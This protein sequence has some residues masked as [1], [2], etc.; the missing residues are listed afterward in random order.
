M[1][2][3]SESGGRFHVWRQRFPDGKPEQLTSGAT[4][5]EGIAVAPDGG[6]FITSVGLREN[7][8]WIQDGR[9]EHQLSSQGFSTNPQF[10]RDGKKLYYLVR[11]HGLSGQFVQGELWV[12]DL[13]NNRSERALPGFEVSGFAVSPDGKDV[14]FAV[15]DKD[16]VP[17][18][19]LAS[20]DLQFSP[21]RFP[22]SVSEDQ[23]YFD[24]A[25]NIYFRAGEGNQNFIYRM[26]IDGSNREKAFGDPILELQTVSPDGKW[27]SVWAT[28]QGTESHNVAVPLHGGN[29]VVLCTGYCQGQWSIDGK[30]F[31]IYLSNMEGVYTMLVSVPSGGLPLL[32]PDGVQT[33]ADMERVKD[34]KVLAGFLMPGPLPGLIVAQRGEVHRNLYRIPL[35]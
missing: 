35:P 32:P 12:A 5:E 21:R 14:V 17:G 3:N 22:S 11:R 7:T 18:L 16:N 2:L 29:P 24:A 19:W 15:T 1:Y 10:S 6:S 9:G 4:E 23:P 31:L 30:T 28:K 13:A 25:G 20:L 8:I 33:R 34:A 26:K 27:A